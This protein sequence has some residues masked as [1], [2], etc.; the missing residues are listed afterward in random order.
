MKTLHTMKKFVVALIVIAAASTA[1]ADTKKHEAKF[2][3]ALGALKTDLAKLDS[4][5]ADTTIGDLR[6]V[7]DKVD[8]DSKDVASE[9]RKMKTPEAKQ[10][11]ESAEQLSKE[12]HNIPD[13]MTISQLHTRIADDVANVKKSAQAVASAS[14][15][16]DAMPSDS[17][18]K[19]TKSTTPT[20]PTPDQP[21]P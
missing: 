6:K 11:T 16:A 15:C 13:N 5:S 17:G 9:A 18:S 2:C 20:P 19:D 10:L 7:T 21:S 3:D 12:T 4:I 14:G 8:K 1:G